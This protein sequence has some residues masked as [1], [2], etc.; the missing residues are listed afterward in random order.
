MFQ[1]A[2]GQRPKELNLLGNRKVK[3]ISA[4]DF[5]QMIIRKTSLPEPIDNEEELSQDEISGINEE[6]LEIWH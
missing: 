2:K 1:K 3:I 4:S 5:A 6:L